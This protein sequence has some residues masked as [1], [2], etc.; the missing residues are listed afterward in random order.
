M[1]SSFEEKFSIMKRIFLTNLIGL[2]IFGFSVYGQE[3]SACQPQNCGPSNTKTAEAKVVTD[4]KAQITEFKASA[5]KHG[6]KPAEISVSSSM[7]NSLP[8]DIENSRDDASIWL[9]Y[10]EVLGYQRSMGK[11]SF[12][13]TSFSNK[14]V[15]VYSLRNEISDLQ[16]RLDS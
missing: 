14:A 11:E 1:E 16:S 2:M 5:E 10:L 3:S 7:F 8:L 13:E 15:L 6:L 4:L 12:D 9:I